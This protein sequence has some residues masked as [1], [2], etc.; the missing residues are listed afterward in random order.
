MK[1]VP[2]TTKVV[3]SNPANGDVYSIQHYVMKFISDLRQVGCFIRVLRFPVDW[4]YITLAYLLH[5]V[6]DYKDKEAHGNDL[7]YLGYCW[8]Y[9]V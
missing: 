1:S 3:S 5:S 6:E 7:V 9:G 4:K 2:I 8:V